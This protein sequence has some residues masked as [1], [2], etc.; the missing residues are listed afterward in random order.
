MRALLRDYLQWNPLLYYAL[1]H[2]NRSLRIIRKQSSLRQRIDD[3]ISEFIAPVITGKKALPTDS[4]I[5]ITN[6]CNL[7][8]VM[9]NIQISKRPQGF[10]TPD[11]FDHILCQLQSV[12]I[13]T[14]GLHTVGE[15]FMYPKL[16]ILLKLAQ[17]R[18]FVVWLST[19]GQFPKKMEELHKHHPELKP[20]SYRFSI[21]GATKET[22]EFIRRGGKFERVFESLEVVH[23]F[24]ESRINKKVHV[25]IDSILSMTN[26]Y[27]I[28]YYFNK[29]GKYC[30]PE[31]INFNLVNGLSPDSSY[32]REA[33]PF[34]NL[35]RQ[36][37]PCRM[38][39]SFVYFTYGGKVT[40]CARDYNE[41][42][43]AGDIM[44]E[45]LIDI[46]N[47]PEAESI[48]KKNLQREEMDISACNACFEAYPFASLI[49]NE[50]IHFLQKRAIGISAE[51]FGNSVISLLKEMDYAVGEQNMAALR[52]S[53]WKAFS[54]LS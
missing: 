52:E 28:P 35:I 33:F 50:Y 19:N 47:G 21:D 11:L 2:L 22:Y 14:I 26:I 53:V 39:F 10:M 24:N 25:F 51:A 40:L 34:A 36:M 3:A 18:R 8:C 16:E 12:G 20:Y 42:I 15:T 6:M 30:W 48:R 4:L 37:T 46:W 38:P 7:N 54:S 43:I 45:S 23:K 13:R 27:E 5:E 31:D 29:F 44:K 49:V 9:C 17:E 41:E 32:F 1:K